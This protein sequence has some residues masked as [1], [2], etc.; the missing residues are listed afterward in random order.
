MWM[1]DF[2]AHTCIPDEAQ[3][4]LL[5]AFGK[6]QA[7]AVSKQAFEEQ[8]FF[9]M[10]E[11]QTRL[12]AALAAVGELAEGLDLHPYT[13]HFLLLV[14]AG[15]LLR[16]QYAFR[17]IDEQVF[18]ATMGDLK[19]KLAECREVHGIWGTFVGW[20][21]KRILS[22]DIFMLGRLQYEH[23]IY[24]LPAA[25]ERAGIHIP[26]GLPVLSIHIPSCGPL[27]QALRLDS[28]R[29]AHAFFK[30]Q[31]QPLVC[32]CDSWLLFPEHEAFL[33][34]NSNILD[35]MR[36]FDIVETKYD[37]EPRGSWRIFGAQAKEPPEAWPE[38]SGLQR[39]YKKRILSG[40]TTGSG[41]GVLL[42]DG[43]TIL[44]RREKR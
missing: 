16:W 19:Y 40:G 5:D 34:E 6:V 23:A 3:A 31:G 12:D 2:M 33:P 32:I 8:V 1:D 15:E 4:Y 35:F 18:W 37:E 41:L 21:Y 9:C 29:Q 38:N 25:Y 24:P 36:D 20:W 11:P 27:T 7:Q 14:Q 28:Y 42:F 22:C 43:E 44:T 10:R 26:R 13:L 30:R 17:G 39:A